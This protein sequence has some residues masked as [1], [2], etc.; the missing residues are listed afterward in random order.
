MWLGWAVFLSSAMLMSKYSP[1]NISSL[2]TFGKPFGIFAIGMFA[3]P[4]LICGGMRFWLAYIRNPWLALPPYMIGIFFAWQA[5]CYGIYLL[6]E[7]LIVFQILSAVLFFFYIPNLIVLK[8]T[9]QSG[10]AKGSSEA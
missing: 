9:K 2:N 1:T 5:T 8:Q 4:I 3:I 7:F 6:P 10:L